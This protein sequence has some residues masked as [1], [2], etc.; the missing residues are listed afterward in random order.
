MGC[1]AVDDMDVFLVMDPASC[2]FG[3]EGW[4]DYKD[5]SFFTGLS[6]LTS[7]L[8]SHFALAKNEKG[9]SCTSILMVPSKDCGAEKEVRYRKGFICN[10][11]KRFGNPSHFEYESRILAAYQ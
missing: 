1:E 9:T 3:G 6:A 5:G 2:D 11:E 4:P 10:L 8:K 7:K